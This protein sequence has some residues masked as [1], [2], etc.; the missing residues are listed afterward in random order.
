MASISTMVMEEFLRS[1]ATQVRKN[2][3]TALSLVDDPD[4]AG[5]IVIT[6]LEDDDPGVRRRAEEESLALDENLL[7]SARDVIVNALTSGDAQKQ[8]RAYALLGR[9]RSNGI[10]L[11]TPGMPWGIRMR[12]AGAMSSF[13]YP[14]RSLSFRLRSWQPGLLG[15]LVGVIPLMLYMV[16]IR[17][18][19]KGRTAITMGLAA[20]AVLLV[21][22]VVSVL[23]TQ[24]STPINLQLRRF[25]AT[26]VEVLATFFISLF[27][28]LI[29]FIVFSLLFSGD[30]RFYGEF[31]LVLLVVPLLALFAA[32]V[33]LG[34]ILAFGRLTFI[35]WPRSK[36]RNWLI[37]IGVGTAVGMLAV[38][39]PIYLIFKTDAYEG[40]LQG[41]R[42]WWLAAFA[43][44]M[45]LA[46]SFA[47]VD[48]EAP[49]RN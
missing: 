1:E 40:D 37:Q 21:G 8:Q 17:S 30:G 45:G 23:A 24:F 43:V 27:G 44:G 32:I 46:S 2:A 48:R 29:V 49:P 42:A 14:V 13:L 11:S 35:Q 33:R 28:L 19:T 26:I 5:L 9:L 12:M 7:N 20:L 25:A 4:S 18:D 3:L 47:K 34:T 6:A 15:S 10:T 38:A 41:Y 36:T 31:G 39:T 22:T 16:A